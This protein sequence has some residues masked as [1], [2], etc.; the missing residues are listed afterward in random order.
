MFCKYSLV[1][2]VIKQEN[3]FFNRHHPKAEPALS[4]GWRYIILGLNI[5]Y[6]RSGWNF[7]HFSTKRNFV[8]IYAILTRSVLYIYAEQLYIYAFKSTKKTI[9]IPFQQS[10]P[11]QPILKFQRIAPKVPSKFSCILPDSLVRTSG[12]S[13]TI[14][15]NFRIDRTETLLCSPTLQTIHLFSSCINI[16]ECTRCTAFPFSEIGME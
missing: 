10:F 16:Q 2:N 12:N 3:F 4:Q 7:A 5:S 1:C 13:P 11:E 6:L 14:P 9:T 15:P 8:S